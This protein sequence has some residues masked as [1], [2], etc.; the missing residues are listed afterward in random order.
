MN[1]C[2]IDLLWNS[3][4]HFAVRAMLLTMLIVGS[5]CCELQARDSQR[6]T[7]KLEKLGTSKSAFETIYK[8]KIEALRQTF[9]TLIA[10]VNES[11]NLRQ[12]DRDTIVTDLKKARDNFIEDGTF[13]KIPAMQEHYV[14]FVVNVLKGYSGLMADYQQVLRMLPQQDN[15]REEFNKEIEI[16]TNRV[17]KYDS[18]KEGTEF[19]GYRSDFNWGQVKGFVASED[20]I[21]LKRIRNAPVDAHIRFKIKKRIG[22][23]L[24]GIVNQGGEFQAEIEG[25]Y[26]GVILNI[27][28]VNILKGNRRYF[29]YSGPVVG[30]IG[31]LKL[32]GVKTNGVATT[33]SI[34]LQRK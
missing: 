32:A 17:A 24:S 13:A 2:G 23:K 10:T 9:D 1:M 11:K 12:E 15:R 31:Q 19:V 25:T 33:G 6:L 16:A 29:E 30:Q 4:W 18:L 20:A 3:L 22:N 26:D 21:R 34:I 7:E 27:R 5:A 8:A 14:D 28:V